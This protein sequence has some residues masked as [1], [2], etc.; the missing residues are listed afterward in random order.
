MSRLTRRNNATGI[1]SFKCRPS[2]TSSQI[3]HK[4]APRLRTTIKMPLVTFF[5][6]KFRIMGGK[7]LE[8]T[9]ASRLNAFPRSVKDFVSNYNFSCPKVVKLDHNHSAV[10][11]IFNGWSFGN[12]NSK[13]W[14]YIEIF[15]TLLI[16]IFIWGTK[17][18]LNCYSYWI[19]RFY[20]ILHILELK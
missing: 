16:K 17:L 5:V 18:A 12:N 2:D 9:Y 6:I 10:T 3:F 11:S 8:I 20:V 4:V 15:S 14:Y 19:F 1:L 13:S 7:T